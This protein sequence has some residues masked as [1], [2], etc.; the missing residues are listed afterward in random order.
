MEARRSTAARHSEVAYVFQ[1]PETHSDRGGT[2]MQILLDHIELFHYCA[3]E[4]D[5]KA[6][7]AARR[8]VEKYAAALE[9]KVYRY[10]SRI[11]MEGL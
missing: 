6:A 9:L 10:A 8:L 1:E 4:E 3:G 2:L 7:E 11:V 5:Y